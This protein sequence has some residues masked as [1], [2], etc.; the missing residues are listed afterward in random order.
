MGLVNSRGPLQGLPLGFLITIP[1]EVVEG[2]V[3]PQ[4]NLLCASSVLPFAGSFLWCFVSKDLILC[5]LVGQAY[6]PFHGYFRPFV[7]L[8]LLPSL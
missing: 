4:R 5:P 1:F 7:A 2:L 6:E 3:E 8:K